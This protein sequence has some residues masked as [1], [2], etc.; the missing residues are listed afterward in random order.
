M[1]TREWRSLEACC[2]LCRGYGGVPP[3][4]PAGDRC[5]CD[6]CEIVNGERGDD[7]ELAAH[8]RGLAYQEREDRKRATPAEVALEEIAQGCG[9][10]SRDPL[11]HATNTIVLSADAR[12]EAP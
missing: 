9:P 3:G 8:W 5:D 6:S 12:E 11:T 7:A 10:F 1:K 2:E 4:E